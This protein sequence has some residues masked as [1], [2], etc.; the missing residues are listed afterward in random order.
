MT[1]ALAA[2]SEHLLALA[3]AVAARDPAPGRAIAALRRDGR[4]AFEASGLPHTGLEEWRYT[5]LSPLTALDLRL[6]ED[7]A[8]IDRALLERVATP[9]FACGL[10]VFANGRPR[11][12]LWG[13]PAGDVEL[14]SLREADPGS[15][16]CGVDPKL[17]PLAALNGAMTED[18]VLVRIPDGAQLE[19]P[20]HL[21]FVSS[22]P[23]TS[24]VSCPRVVIEAGAG[25][26]AVVIQDHVCVGGGPAHFTNAVTEVAVGENADLAFA[27]VQREGEADIHASNLAVRQERD[28]RFASHVVTLGG[29]LVR[30]DLTVVLAGPGAECVL[31]G[32]YVGTGERLVDNHTLVDHAVPHGTSHELYKGVLSDASRGVFRGRVV[33]RP[34]A[35][36]TD[37]TQQNPNL[38]LSDGTEIDTK[39]QLEIHADD[40]KCSHGSAIGRIDEDALFYLRTRG[41]GQRDARALLTRGFAA[42]ILGALPGEAL[43]EALTADFIARLSGGTGA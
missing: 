33:V 22:S 41:I 13:V 18:G 8:Q 42:E 17:H 12:A 23:G 37:A 29:R 38:L 32:L 27:L 25:C 10:A 19:H 11:N 16:A 14:A 7:D 20:V 39:P 6:S 1:A 28:S 35:Q 15:L 24:S 2:A 4:T 31:N 30:N 36:K 34:D 21:V 43:A 5:G 3:D 40:V 9:V 26:R